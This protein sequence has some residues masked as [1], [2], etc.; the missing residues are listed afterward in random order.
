MSTGKGNLQVTKPIVTDDF[1]GKATP[2]GYQQDFFNC[3]DSHMDLG[4]VP[5]AASVLFVVPDGVSAEIVDIGVTWPHAFTFEASHKVSLQF[6][7]L[8]ADGA[9]TQQ[10]VDAFDRTTAVTAGLTL[11]TGRGTM[12]Y[13]T[14][15]DDST[16]RT[17][18][19]GTIISVGINQT[20]TTGAG[21]GFVAWVRLKYVST[22][23]GT[24]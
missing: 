22:D 4:G 1:I 8:G 14:A 7:V 9:A 13:S 20:G 3:A 12:T 10:I 2:P 21:A 24:V 15:S 18:A 16:K 6:A 23:L 11:S 17:L 19:A 5:N